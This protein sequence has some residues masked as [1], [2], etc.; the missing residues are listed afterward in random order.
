MWKIPK[1]KKRSGIDEYGRNNLHEAVLENLSK[2]VRRFINKGVDIN[3]SDDNGFTALHFAVQE[4]NR[5]IVKILLEA[6]ASVDVK[7]SY[8]NTPLMRALNS[9]Y[10]AMASN[11]PDPGA[12]IRMLLQ[13]GADPDSVNNYGVRIIDGAKDC[14]R[15]LMQFFDCD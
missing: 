2:K 9:C 5:E 13:A 14:D 4:N 10:A 6:G 1:K 12:I 11:A 8:G 3:A 15:D 7:D